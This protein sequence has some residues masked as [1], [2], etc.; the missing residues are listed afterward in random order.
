MSPTRP[1]LADVI[2]AAVDF[3]RSAGY[4]VDDIG[5]DDFALQRS[6]AGYS[7]ATYVTGAYVITATITP[8][9]S[10]ST[11]VGEIT[12]FAPPDAVADVEAGLRTWQ[13]IGEQAGE[14]AAQAF[15]EAV[16]A[17]V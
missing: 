10:A 12:W 16:N 6:P 9:G 4:D 11:D 1:D 8:D 14:L 2:A 13:E 17:N 3:A 15:T 5:P 7:H